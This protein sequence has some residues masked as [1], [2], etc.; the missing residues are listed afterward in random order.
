M[1]E[2]MREVLNVA[3]AVHELTSEHIEDVVN[4]WLDKE[5]G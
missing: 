3:Y 4:F 1:I 2:S 5:N